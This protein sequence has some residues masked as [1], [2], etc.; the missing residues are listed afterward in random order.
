MIVSSV[1]NNIM[2]KKRF[3]KE[4]SAPT[5][6]VSSDTNSV[7]GRSASLSQ[8]IQK[9]IT[10]NYK[11]GDGKVVFIKKCLKATRRKMGQTKRKTATNLSKVKAAS[12]VKS[13]D[14]KCV[15]ITE[16]TMTTSR[17]KSA[18]ISKIQTDTSS[19]EVIDSNKVKMRKKSVKVKKS[20]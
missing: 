9:Y 11:L 18:R 20:K 12:N 7:S 2:T 8:A 13:I 5:S 19:S 10:T 6:K 17:R 3:V 14:E 15:S 1:K 16:T 4:F